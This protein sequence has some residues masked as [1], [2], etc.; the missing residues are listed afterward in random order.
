LAISWS[1]LLQTETYYIEKASVGNSGF[2][3]NVAVY[4]FFVESI[5]PEEFNKKRVL[6]VGSKYV[7]GSVR[8]LIE[9]FFSPKEYIGV[10]VELGKY[11]DLILPAEKL[12]WYFGHESFDVVIATEL[13]EHVKDWRLVVNNMKMILKWGGYVYI[14]TRSK[15]FPHHNFPYDF[16]RYEVDD[17]ERIFRDFETIA[18]EK[19]HLSPGILFKARKP[20]NQMPADLSDTALYSMVLGKRTREILNIEDTPFTRRLALRLSRSRVRRL[21]P[22]V[23]LGLLET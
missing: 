6:E 21:L 1:H 18:V 11:V 17:I 14:T 22:S 19:D 8:P 5:K 3:C 12:L 13:L 16:W 23:L 9:K 7:N 2:V 20:E 10:D 4:E 15:G